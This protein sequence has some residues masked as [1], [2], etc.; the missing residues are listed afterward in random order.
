[1]LVG[2]PILSVLTPVLFFQLG[3]Y[4]G[5]VCLVQ[6]P[7]ASMVYTLV[8]WLGDR[9][10]TVA[11][12]RRFPDYRMVKKRLLYAGLLVV[13][14]TVLVTFGMGYAQQKFGPSSFMLYKS[15]SPWRIVAGS[16]FSTA[17]V[18]LIY[19]AVYFVNRWKLSMIEAERLREEQAKSQLEAL[20]NQVNPHF[21]FNSLNTLVSLIP[22]DQQK[23][24][25][26]VQKLSLVYRSVLD[27]NERSVV[28]LR[29]ELD[30]AKNYLFLVKTR[31][32]ESFSYHIQIADEALGR[33]TVPLALQMLLENAIKH[34]VVSR[35][36]PLHVHMEVEGEWL[37][38][39][40][41][42]QP[43][44]EEQT[45]PGTGLRNLES[46]YRLL[47][48][49]SVELRSSDLFFEVRLPLVEILEK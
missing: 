12:R 15:L 14:Y 41:N 7:V 47:F 36:R 9:Q 26:F 21:L 32:E 45:K 35:R 17:L 39:R 18:V 40:N 5:L 43:K 34:N 49:R 25:D 24:V 38:V 37:V 48:D 29:E 8:Y 27:L 46:R 28:S 20:R 30:L 42:L 13:L 23:A 19:E 1:M 31:F 33:Y 22:E 44:T 2:V 3:L 10:I 16:L 11:L 4:E 6:K